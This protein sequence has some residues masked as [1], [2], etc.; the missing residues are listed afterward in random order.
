[1]LVLGGVR[2]AAATR[3]LVWFIP[4]SALYNEA[5]TGQTK[6]IPRCQ[7]C[8][9]EKHTL[10]NCPDCPLDM[11]RNTDTNRTVIH[12]SAG[13]PHPSIASYFNQVR[14]RSRRCKYQHLCNLCSLLHPAQV[15]LMYGRGQQDRSC[16]S[17]PCRGREIP[18][19]P[20]AGDSSE[21]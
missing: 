20:M 11:Q 13:N 19:V 12:R 14:C 10:N 2:Q 4:N 16:P 17:S 21:Q 8:L 5:F 1:M 9:S 7:H 15:C 18:K 6:A 3:N